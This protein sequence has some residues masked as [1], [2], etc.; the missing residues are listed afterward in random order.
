MFFY[1]SRGNEFAANIPSNTLED[2]DNVLQTG[3][4]T[5]HATPRGYSLIYWWWTTTSELLLCHALQRGQSDCLMLFRRIKSWFGCNPLGM[6]LTWFRW[7][8]DRVG[9]EIGVNAVVKTMVVLNKSLQE[10][11]HSVKPR[12]RGFKATPS[13]SQNS[14]CGSKPQDISFPRIGRHNRIVF[15]LP[16]IFG[17]GFYCYSFIS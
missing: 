11:D 4:Q 17:C 2:K 10:N 7:K 3:D 13:V 5:L 14:R 16:C 8:H 6:V 15:S 12:I 9:L 1:H